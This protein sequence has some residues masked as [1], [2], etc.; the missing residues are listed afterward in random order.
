MV[1]VL[2]G[3]HSLA[4]VIENSQLGM[5]GFGEKMLFEKRP[6]RATEVSRRRAFQ[7]EGTAHAKETMK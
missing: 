5:Q 3:I 7:A 2:R 1:A 6:E 4:V